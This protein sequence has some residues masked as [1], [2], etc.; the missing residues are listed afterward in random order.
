MCITYCYIFWTVSHLFHNFPES[1]QQFNC[2]WINR[3]VACSTIPLLSVNDMKCYPA[4]S[5][6]LQRRLEKCYYDVMRYLMFSREIWLLNTLVTKVAVFQQFYSEI[7][8]S[9]STLLGT[10]IFYFYFSVRKTNFLWV[11]FSKIWMIRFFAIVNYIW[12]IRFFAIVNYMVQK[13]SFCSNFYVDV[14]ANIDL[15]HIFIDL[16]RQSLFRETWSWS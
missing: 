14:L 9:L 11:V 8:F 16:K 2:C 15:L 12:M 1:R 7:I 13:F 4:T 3:F 10:M 5:P 6:P